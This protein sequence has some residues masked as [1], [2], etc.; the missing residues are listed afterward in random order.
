MTLS[1]RMASRDSFSAELLQVIACGDEATELIENR[2]VTIFACALE[3]G[4]HDAALLHGISKLVCC[5]ELLQVIACGDEATEL[6]ENRAVPSK[7]ILVT[8]I[9]GDAS[10]SSYPVLPY[11]E[12]A[13]IRARAIDRSPSSQPPLRS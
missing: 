8:F 7:N 1:F 5:A 12:K 9:L 11:C 10:E 3:C 13:L 2:A 6:V 4:P